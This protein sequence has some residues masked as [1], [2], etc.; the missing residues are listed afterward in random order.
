[1]ARFEICIVRPPRGRDSEAFREVAESLHYALLRL[2]HRSTIVENAFSSEVTSIVLGADLLRQPALER[3]P[4]SAIVYNLEQITPERAL[5]NPDYV[6]L[7][8]RRRVWD[9]SARNLHAYAA[10]GAKVQAELLP[11]GYVPELTR[12]A[13]APEQDIDVLFYGS[14]NERRIPVL[15][16]LADAGLRAKVVSAV[17]GPARDALIA[18]AKLVLNLHFYAGNPFEIVRVSYLLANRKAVVSETSE[19]AAPEDGLAD[20]VR[21]AAREELTDA[22]V[23]LAYDT[24]R[25]GALEERGYARFSKRRLEERLAA[26]V[27]PATWP[28]PGS[29]ARYPLRLRIGGGADSPVDR[30]DVDAGAR[31]E[32]DAVIDFGQPL[33]LPLK[34]RTARFGS[35]PLYASM[36]DEIVARDVPGRSGEWDAAMANWLQLLKP[37]GSLRLTFA[38]EPGKHDAMPARAADGRSWVRYTD[39]FWRLGW[40][41]YRFELVDRRYVLSPLGRR[42]QDAGRGLEEILRE[43]RAVEEMTVSLRKVF[44]TDQE[45]RLGAGMAGGSRPADGSAGRGV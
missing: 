2:G 1:M 3:V 34:L 17:Y 9:Y 13:A 36:F 35:L 25:R 38:P 29:A 15:E 11:V 10:L 33:A 18:R 43:P 6:E 14:L 41:E 32:A 40:S 30:L 22:C 20:A 4:E 26:L 37:G 42:L 21:F 8:Q 27:G 5:D 12:I 7:L 45:A 44:L 16:E 24:A 19:L 23:E 31:P 28:A 39:E